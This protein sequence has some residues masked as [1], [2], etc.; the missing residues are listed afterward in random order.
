M[1]SWGT[2][3]QGGTLAL[4]LLPLFSLSPCNEGPAPT[5]P[6]GRAPAVLTHAGPVLSGAHTRWPQWGRP[7]AR[8]QPVTSGD[9]SVGR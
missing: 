8:A 1:R 5:A 4:P 6:G 7:Q 3:G 2:G 9:A